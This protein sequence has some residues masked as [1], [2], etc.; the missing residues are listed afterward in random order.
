MSVTYEESINGWYGA[1]NVFKD[2][3]V[4]VWQEGSPTWW[5]SPPYTVGQF[6]LDLSCRSSIYEV[7]IRNSHNWN[8]RNVGT[9]KLSLHISNNQW[10]PWTEFFNTTFEDPRGMEDPVPLQ[11]FTLPNIAVGRFIKVRVDEVWG[12]GAALQF[13]KVSGNSFEVKFEAKHAL[14]PA[15]CDYHPQINEKV[16][17]K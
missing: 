4:D 17:F 1:K 9:K 11:L 5:H 13:F 15:N 2:A 8:T 12:L 7:K 3:E 10:G 6:H 16:D 14:T